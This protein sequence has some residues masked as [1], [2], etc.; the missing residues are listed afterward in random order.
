[1]LGRYLVITPQKSKLGNHHRNF[2]L[3]KQEIFRKLPVQKIGRTGP[4][5]IP[6]NTTRTYNIV[7]ATFSDLLELNCDWPKYL[8]ENFCLTPSD[9]QL[10]HTLNPDMPIVNGAGNQSTWR[11]PLPNPNSHR[12]WRLPHMPSPR[13]QPG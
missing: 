10:S 13:C 5:L 7:F 11:K 1:M 8:G 6:D 3:S 4:G 12:H 2:C 9:W